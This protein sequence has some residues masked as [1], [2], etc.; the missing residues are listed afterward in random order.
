MYDI[1][2]EAIALG[3]KPGVL[4]WRSLGADRKPEYH[5]YDQDIL[6]DSVFG[7]TDKAR[8]HVERWIEWANANPDKAVSALTGEG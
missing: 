3:V 4:C 8:F 6:V 2:K 1:A 7:L 5:E